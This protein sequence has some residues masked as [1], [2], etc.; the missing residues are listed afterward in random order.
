MADQLRMT[1]RDLLQVRLEQCNTLH[2]APVVDLKLFILL[3]EVLQGGGKLPVGAEEFLV[4][5]HTGGQIH[6]ARLILGVVPAEL[7]HVSLKAT[8]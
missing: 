1:I 2:Q 6:Q 8:L 4:F 5:I 7:R 3:L